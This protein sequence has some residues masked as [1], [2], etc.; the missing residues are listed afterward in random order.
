MLL[1]FYSFIEY[2]NFCLQFKPKED[3]IIS[4]KILEEKK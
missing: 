4:R 3:L 1:L 2:E